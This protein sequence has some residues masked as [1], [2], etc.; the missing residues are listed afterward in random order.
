V[1]VT[2]YGRPECH[3][4][5]QAL[6]QIEPILGERPGSVLEVVDIEADDRLLKLYL[7]R[8]PVVE[9][10]GQ[11]VSELVFD[12]AGLRAALGLP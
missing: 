6:E 5:D 4:C 11:V 9:A 10:G 8:I 7:E 1:K 12:P 2:V 3:L